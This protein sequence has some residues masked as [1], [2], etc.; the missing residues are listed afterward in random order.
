MTKKLSSDKVTLDVLYQSDNNYA[1]VTGVSIVS[2]LENNR[3][4]DELTV[5]LVDGGIT[6][7][8][9][10]H[11]QAIVKRYG[12]TLNVIDGKLIEERLKELNCRP[13]KGSYVT[14][15]KLL[16]YN[17]IKS[18]AERVLM[19]DGD[20]LILQ[21]LRELCLM[22]L[23]GYIMAETVDPY[24]PRYLT[25]SIGIPDGQ[26]YYSAGVMLINQREWKKQKCEQQIID[27]WKH[28]KSDYLFADQDITNVLFGNKIKE[29]HIK[30]NFYSKNFMIHPYERL[31]MKLNKSM[32]QD[33]IR[34]GAVCVHCI[35]ESWRSRPWFRGNTHTMN[36]E[37]D[38]YLALTPWKGWKKLDTKINTFHKL[39]R[40][41]YNTL[42]RPL[43]AVTLKGV[44]GVFARLSISKKMLD[45]KKMNVTD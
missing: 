35:D 32:L 14:Y 12:R 36:K 13:Y 1:V 28:K 3:D 25:K 41:V 18:K 10:A 27:H 31:L 9:L 26:P 5:N 43:Y 45:S 33:V 29:L 44:S 30:Y 39:D 2:L 24:M 6:K 16:A 37:W 22:S 15:Y 7:N 17:M 19:L 38:N 11:I 40:I 34:G 21:S 8:N 20:I 23:D 42:P 4:I